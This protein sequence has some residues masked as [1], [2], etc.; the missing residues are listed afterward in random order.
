MKFLI[1]ECLSPKLAELARAQGH[2]E[3]THVVWLGKEGTKDW[4]LMPLIVDG[5]WTLVTR[6]AIDF[7]GAPGRPGEKGHYARL[8]LHAGLICLNAPAPMSREIQIEL[9]EQVIAELGAESDLVNQVLEIS[10]EPD[11]TLRIT[12]Y[13][14]PAFTDARGDDAPVQDE[15]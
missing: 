4:D 14:L 11:D 8:D 7:R 3:S 9:F 2:V 1:D 12:R 15:P 10:L 5:D 6:N 13:D